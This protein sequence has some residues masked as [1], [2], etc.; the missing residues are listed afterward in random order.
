MKQRVPQ[1]NNTSTDNTSTDNTSTDNTSTQQIIPRL[2]I[3]QLIIPQRRH[4][5]IGVYGFSDVFIR[6]YCHDR[7]M[8]SCDGK[9]GYLKDLV[10][11][12]PTLK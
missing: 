5:I 10:W 12:L 8:I 4:Q 3:P 11:I 7:K 9:S 2:I 6:E 1:T